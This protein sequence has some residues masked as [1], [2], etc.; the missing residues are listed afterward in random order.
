MDF[1]HSSLVTALHEITHATISSA[2]VSNPYSSTSFVPPIRTDWDL[3]FQ[4]M[5]DEL[6]NPPTSFDPPA[7]E[8]IAS[9]AK[10]VAPKP[11]ASIG[12]PSLTTVDQDAPSPSYSQTLPE[13]QS[14]II[15]DEVKEENHDLYVS[16]MNN[17]PFFVISILENVSDASFSLD[18][19]PT[20]VHTAA[21][22]LEHINK[23]T[24]DHPLDNI[25]SELKRPVSTKKLKLDEDPQRKGVDPTHYRGM[26]DALMYLTASG[27]DLTFILCMCA[28]Y[29]AKPT[30]KQ[31]H[32]VKRI[33]KYL[34]GAIN[35][36]L[37]NPKD[38]SI[39]LTAYAD[40][41]HAGCQDTIQS[42]SGGTDM[43]V[44]KPDPTP[45]KPIRV[46]VRGDPGHTREI[47][48]LIDVNVNNMH[49]PWRSFAAI[50]NRCLSGKTTGL[51]ILRLSRAQ[52]I[53]GMYHKKNVDYV[54]LL[55]EDLV[56]QVENKNSKKNNDMCYLRFTKVII[57]YFR[58]KDQSISRRHKMFWHTARDDPMFNTIRVISRHQDIH[59]YDA[60]LPDELTNQEMLDSKGYKE[61]Y[62]VS[63]GAEPP[64]AKTK[65]KK[66]ANE[67]VT[68]SKSKCAPAANGTRLKT[69]TKV[70]DPLN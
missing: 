50:I 22:N 2:L 25:I 44:K 3:L 49:Q 23:W 29:Q 5:F 70:T 16:H 35:R 15:S 59:I 51:D 43:G 52:I 36:G 38:F 31:L 47:K 30:E 41:D 69:P 45:I 28:R 60:I 46:V 27:A 40:A 66:K 67:P 9:I 33:F 37:W 12:L 24:K 56:Y 1:K 64:K 65:Y 32:A 26:A 58:S 61:Y 4:L 11:A 20:V 8:V 53:W 7:P 68:P 21:P 10:V 18:V 63:S 17:D 6:L 42:T 55:W 34:R 39:A 48:V 13:T 14:L 62:V 54:Y 57:D 19:I